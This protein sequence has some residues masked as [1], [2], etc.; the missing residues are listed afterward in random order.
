MIMTDKEIIQE[1]REAKNKATQI[2]I[3]AD[4]NLCRQ[5]DIVAILRE[6]GQPVPNMWLNKKEKEEKIARLAAAAGVKAPAPEPTKPAPK[7]ATSEP[8]IGPTIAEAAIEAIA[9]RLKDSDNRPYEDRADDTLERAFTFRE[10][11]R[12]ILALIYELEAAE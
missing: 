9:K 7:A 11:V 5:A 3:L 6:A 10:Q 4:E 12:G 8:A 2:K 1:Y